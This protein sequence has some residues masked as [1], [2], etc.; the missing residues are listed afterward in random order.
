MSNIPILI[1]SNVKGLSERNI[2]ALNSHN[3][4]FRVIN[5]PIDD[6]AAFTKIINEYFKEQNAEHIVIIENS[7]VIERRLINYIK[8]LEHNLTFVDF[9]QFAGGRLN[10]LNILNWQRNLKI[11]GIISLL[12]I[13]PD[14]LIKSI[15]KINVMFRRDNQKVI[16]RIKSAI[17]LK[18]FLGK[19]IAEEPNNPIAK[20]VINWNIVRLPLDGYILSK[21]WAE[22]MERLSRNSI[23]P[24]QQ[25]HRSL[26]RSGNFKS[27]SKSVLFKS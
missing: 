11:A 21:N 18:D 12:Q 20:H 5:F 22:N 2:Y 27:T 4:T 15:L 16:E 17:I 9:F 6:S 10:F 25:I 19:L 23:L 13:T 8:K 14:Y 26:A 24:V 1:I 7:K 3:F